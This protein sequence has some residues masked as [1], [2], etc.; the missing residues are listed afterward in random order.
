MKHTFVK[1]PSG[2]VEIEHI[3][4]M[5]SELKNSEWKFMKWFS[6]PALINKKSNTATH[7]YM[8]QKFDEQYFKLEEKGWT[9]DHCE[10]CFV[11][12]GESPNDYTETEGYFNGDDWICKF[13]FNELVLAENLENKLTSLEQYQE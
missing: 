2:N 1:L 11:S 7:L 4:E 9:H 5:V 13:C 6:R 10:I 12:I 3:R 8:G